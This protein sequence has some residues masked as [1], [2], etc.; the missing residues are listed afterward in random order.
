VTAIQLTTH[1]SESAALEIDRRTVK[2][3]HRDKLMEIALTGLAHADEVNMWYWL[4][5]GRLTRRCSCRG[6]ADRCASRSAS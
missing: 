5:E 4:L 2:R 3:L 1:V 6:D